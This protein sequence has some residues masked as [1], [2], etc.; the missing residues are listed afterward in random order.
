MTNEELLEQIEEARSNNNKNW[1]ALIRLAMRLSPDE[2]KGIL[3]AIRATD[4]QISAYFGKL[5][6]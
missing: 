2:T 3:S 1:M 5:S 6:E 4:L